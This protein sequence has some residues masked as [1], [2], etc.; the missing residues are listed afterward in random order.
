MLPLGL[1]G[2]LPRFPWI[3]TVLSFVLAGYFVF[4]F[5]DL[6]KS[7][8]EIKTTITQSNVASNLYELFYE[9]CVL[10]K[11][12]KDVC[13][14]GAVQIGRSFYFQE[15]PQPK[16][17]VKLTFK[18]ASQLA[19]TKAIFLKAWGRNSPVITQL[20]HF[21]SYQQAKNKLE[22]QLKGIHKKYNFYS[23]KNRSLKALL[24][25]QLKHSGVAH[26]IG[27]LI[28]LVFFGC[29]LEMRLEPTVFLM[30]YLLG[31]MVGIPGFVM[32][33][34]EG[35]SHVVGAS[36]NIS[37][38]IG[39]FFVVFY[40]FRMLV[41]FAF[42]YLKRFFLPVSIG[43]PLLFI[44]SDAIGLSHEFDGLGGVAHSAHL[45]GVLIG[46]IVGF[47]EVQTSP[48]KWPFRNHQ[49]LDTVRALD[50]LLS[51]RTKAELAKEILSN[52]PD[53]FHAH[54]IVL[55]S[56]LAM[57]EEVDSLFVHNLWREHLPALM[58]LCVRTQSMEK[59]IGLL[60]N[61]PQGLNLP[62][63]LV[64]TSRLV[65]LEVAD[66]LVDQGELSIGCLLYDTFIELYPNSPNTPLLRKTKQE[67]EVI[68][69]RQ[70]KAEVR[71]V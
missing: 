70:P 22:L 12:S 53:N 35:M 38:I 32:L 67:I 68:L 27:N 55:F 43:V 62:L 37:A 69:L 64:N 39:A 48:L 25:A 21:G 58:S 33:N 42:G 6:Q 1:G 71:A 24:L 9:Y 56:S 10:K 16:Q 51:L 23:S 28:V 20:S 47:L 59:L 31:G 4:D 34:P 17:K 54:R 49:E 15:F 61:L 60:N 7:E 40:R 30:C 41:G 52:N 26:L 5:N 8:R 65:I 3:T 11:V 19:S 36:A 66:F 46:I 63:V 13:H 14:E 2:K 44:I 57:Q 45:W 50:K 18:E 29:Y